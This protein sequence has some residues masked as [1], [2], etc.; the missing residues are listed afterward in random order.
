MR[1][2]AEFLGVEFDDIL[3][4]PTFNKFPLNVNTGL[5]VK[6]HGNADSPLSTERSLTGQEVDVIERVTS[7][8]YPLV[9]KKVVRFE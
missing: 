7:E 5:N 4:L 1:F 2:L 3:M 9:L 8:T 6:D